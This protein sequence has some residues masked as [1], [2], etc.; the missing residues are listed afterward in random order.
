VSRVVTAFRI[1]V[2]LSA[3]ALLAAGSA[4]AQDN[5]RGRNPH[6]KLQEECSTCHKSE[7]WTPVRISPK[8]DHAKKGFPLT[9]AHATTACRYCHTSLEFSQVQ[10][11]CAACHKD[12]HQGELGANCAQC[13]SNRSFLDRSAMVRAHQT[14]RFPLSG[15]HLTADCESC[16]TPSSRGRLTF[17]NR[18]TT[19]VECHLSD[20]QATRNPSHQAGGFPKDCIQCHSTAAWPMARFD[21]SATRFPLTGAHR[22]VICQQCHGD[23]VYK[24]KSTACVACHQTDYNGTNDPSHKAAGF[25]T[26][27]VSCHTTTAWTGAT[28]NHNT[29]QFPLTG[30]HKTVACQQCHGDGVYK[31]K[32]TACVA[33]HQA[34]Y[35]ATT[36]PNHKAAQFPTDCASCHTTTTWS[37]ATFNHDASFFPVYSGAHR[38]Q[39]SAC[40]TCH[41]NSSNYAQFTC[42]VCHAH[43]QATTNSHHTQVNGYRYDSQACYSCH[44]RGTSG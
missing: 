20:Y 39:W 12:V 35:N 6:G 5:D 13:H 30:A 21:H 15:A 18:P 36:D 42:L 38:N 11:T 14:T 34:D 40:S 32:S 4:T 41:T 16:H 28:F 2:V 3:C 24:G 44:P 8:F 37:G 27:C 29:T 43:D 23:G 22:A 10:Q 19:C 25:S 7:G 26:D 31:G 1:G 17:V 33:C 9:G